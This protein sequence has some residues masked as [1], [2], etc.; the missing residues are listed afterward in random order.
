MGAGQGLL[1]RNILTYLTTQAPACLQAT[2]YC[3][4]ERSASLIAQQKKRL[5]DFP[6]QWKSW[7]EIDSQSIIG[8]CFSNEL[9]DAFPVHQFVVKAKELYEVYVTTLPGSEP[10]PQFQEVLAEPSTATL[11]T[12]FDELGINIKSYPD[13]YRSEVNLAALEW[14][15]TVSDRLQQGYLLTIDYGYLAHRYY[16]LARREGTLQ[17][18]Y[19]HTYH[20]DP[21]QQVGQQDLTAHVNFTALEQWGDQQGLQTI[22][23]IEQG[24]FLMALGLGDRIAAL[25]NETNAQ[26]SDE[27]QNCLRRRQF[28]HT[29]IDPF[30]MG[31]FGVL[32]QSKGLSAKQQQQSLKGL[33][34]PIM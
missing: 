33:S 26:T 1:A 13:G 16:S 34:I 12:Y 10:N 18:Y 19:Q 24:L 11:L 23:F 8:C 28:L 20:S 30:G 5:Q 4:V 14:L 31:N 27:I 29:L 17:C 15:K 2:Q 7:D 22:G 32:V 9:I 21:Y 25:S 6:V 3:I